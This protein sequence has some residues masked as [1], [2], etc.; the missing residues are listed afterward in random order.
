[1]MLWKGRERIWKEIFKAYFK[2]R[3]QDI[4]VCIAMDYGLNGRDLI[5][6]RCKR[7][8]FSRPQRPER[9]A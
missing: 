5:P 2:A 9:E 3:S 4:S 8:L 1:M 6:G 7:K